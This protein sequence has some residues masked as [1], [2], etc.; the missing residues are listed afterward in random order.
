MQKEMINKLFKLFFEYE[1]ENDNLVN[2]TELLS[3]IKSYSDI[4]NEFRDLVNKKINDKVTDISY[5]CV[6]VNNKK[7][8]FLVLNFFDYII[9]D[10]ENNII[11]DDEKILDIYLKRY[12]SQVEKI[13][14]KGDFYNLKGIE[15]SNITDLIEFIKNNRYVLENSDIVYK[16]KCDYGVVYLILSI[17]SSDI[18]LYFNDIDG[19]KQSIFFDSN[20]SVIESKNYLNNKEKLDDVVK[21]ICCVGVPSELI[22]N[23]ILKKKVK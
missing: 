7:Y 19:N 14:G 21:N 22:P 16:K 10:V 15:E 5:K 20:L 2:I 13:F 3:I 1:D 12:N 8:V 9:I 18:E 11:C 6:T 17:S 4:W 23:K